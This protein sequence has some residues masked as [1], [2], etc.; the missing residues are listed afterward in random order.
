[1]A[2]SCFFIG[3][4]DTNAKI[5]PALLA[6]VE[7]HVTEYGVTD[8]FVGHYGNF[9][10]MAAQAVKETKKSHPEVR[11][12]LVLPYHPALRPIG[13]PAGFNGTYYPWEGERIP[14]R[15]AII[16]TNQRMVD[17]CDYLIAYARHFLG[18]SGQIVEHAR[19]REKQGLIHVE[20]LA[21]NCRRTLYKHPVVILMVATSVS[22]MFVF[23]TAL[24]EGAFWKYVGITPELE[25]CS[26]CEDGNGIRYH[27]PALINLNIGMV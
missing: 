1:M 26:V 20:N 9:D 19:K 21:E 3:H 4:R 18:G 25:T 23:G 15:L 10:R 7:R 16:K 27:A 13:A 24:W 22:L 11:L 2:K 5:Y 8:F 17:T 12:T 14:K 6:E